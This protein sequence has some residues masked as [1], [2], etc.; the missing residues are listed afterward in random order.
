[1]ER[2]D[3]R[4]GAIAAA[5][6][7]A[8]FLFVGVLYPAP[9]PVLFLGL[10]LGSL[11]AL[12]AMGLVL[13]YRANHIVNF[14]QGSLGAV[15][16]ILAASLIV[17]PGWPF[18][19][20][21]AVGLVTAIVLGA[22]VEVAVI[23]RFAK[24]PRLVLTVATIGVGLLLDVAT[25]GIP[26][27][28]D[29]DSMPQPPVPFHFRLRWFPV[30]FNAG[31][32]L[33]VLVV[34]VVGVL[35]AV[36]FRKTRI[37]IA[38]RAS[39]ESSDRAALLGVPVKRVNTLVWVVAAAMSGL[40]VLLR[41]PIQGVAI[42]QVLGPSLLLRALAAAVIGRMESLPR[43]FVAAITLGMVEQA[44]LFETHRTIV[45]DGVL[46][47]VILVAL[48]VQ[49]GGAVERARD[50][51]ISTWASTKEVRP[52]PR[53][54]MALR[55][56]K[57]GVYGLGILGALAL[58][59][60]PLTWSASRVNLFGIG[61]VS[62]M[63]ICSLVILTGWAGQISLGQY[64]FVA[65]GSSVA[66]TLALQ[67][68]NFFVCLLVAGLVGAAISV[69]IGIPALRIRGP[70]F[71]V[72]SLAFALA[73][74]TYFLNREFFRWLVP[75]QAKRIF[76]PV[77]FDKFDLESEHTYYFVL[78]VAFALTAAAVWRLRNSRT[79]R[80][81][82]ANRDNTRAAQSY[83]ISP[84]RAQ[85]T[86]FA[87]SGLIAG[88]AG[89][90]YVFDQRGLSSTLLRP[91]SS[92]NL[93]AIAVVGGL[94]SVPGAIL[95]SAYLTWVNYSPFTRQVLSRLLASGIGLLGI[96][97]VAPGGLN[98]LMYDLRDAILR[99]IARWRGVVVPS[100]LAD[101]RVLE[102][103]DDTLDLVGAEVPT[104]EVSRPSDDPL[105]VVRDLEV[106][107]GRTQVLF[108]VDFHVERG[109]IVAL[110]G[111][112]G[113]GK[114]TLLSAIAGRV[115]P[116]AGTV[117]YDGHD[118][119]GATPGT[120]VGDG[121]V[122]VPGGKGVFP[123]L[124]VAENLS[125]AGWLYQRDPEYLRAATEQVLEFFPVL[126]E[127]W[128]QR[129]GN[130]SGGEQQMLT[131]GQ[132]FIAKP[133]LLMIDELSLGLAPVIVE[134]LLDIVRAIHDSGTTIVLV[135]QSVNVAITIA[136]RAVFMEKGEVRFDGPTSDL[137]DRPDILRA[138]FL[139]GA[140]AGTKQPATAAA[141]ALDK[142]EFVP[143]CPHCGREHPLALELRDVAVSFGGV[144]AVRG[145]DLSLREG[146][147]V[148]IIG[149]NG[150]GKTTVLDLISGFVRPD[151]GRVLLGADDVTELTPWARAH[152]GLGR[153]FQDAR[154]FP[155]MTVRQTIA[156]ALERHV[157]V[158]DALAALVLSPAVTA[159]ERQ[160][161]EEVTRLIDLMGL[162]AFADKFVG[163]LSTGS[164]R[165]VDLACVLAHQ[166]T[167]LLLDEPSSGIA[168]RETEA[169]GPLL[170]DIR[171][172]TGAA[173][174]V[175]EHDMPLITSI[176]DELVALELGAVIATGT[177]DEVIHD[178]QV[179][180]G[181][182]GGTEEIIRRSGDVE[183]KG[184]R[185]RSEPIKAAGR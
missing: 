45:V 18:F 5:G 107:Y 87:L 2:N 178:P 16:A 139:E 123:T 96:L 38:V 8:L 35:L 94:G 6:L 80:A 119:T 130:L 61:V 23:R 82:V 106:A 175:I 165:I 122:L 32:L 21:V 55:E 76:R 185:R 11:S 62:A 168:Q 88:V 151:S 22:V 95:G 99:R 77:L 120:V 30:V 108:G 41:L 52:I 10:V 26:K 179:V 70:F 53:E 67:G 134:Q 50:A 174:I 83:G 91:E 103:S 163:E 162:G 182:L 173:M 110:L 57:V 117:T 145:V 98:G 118:L 115:R 176:S 65:W 15:A 116:A 13:V 137:L 111:T 141:P 29:Y 114:S 86:A 75:D 180:E 72:T 27:L 147:I 101:V 164:R 155:A 171:R 64:A 128:D 73:T 92:L 34:P 142:Q 166:P 36:F 49:R 81:L 79:G 112:N 84:I 172:Q 100:L 159:S 161:D 78:L 158:P 153:S 28:F 42:G 102:E 47:G 132:A 4:A 69:A 19:P 104:T 170:L 31:H 68:K 156:T 48:L 74:G 148:G 138:V 136:Q 140:A 184:K 127:R 7:L 1:V 154:L 40:G 181:Y 113:A 56:V 43:T 93:F 146:Q 90:L 59:F 133:K 14:A 20:A 135:E 25:L 131:L 66:G 150:A 60:V 71:A 97:L 17:G 152:L 51:G 24:A 39:A 121:V 37:G 54:L 63:I 177:P 109:E 9:M 149:P 44:V 85:L 160:V 3:A 183:G 58:V 157:E 46:F 12:V 105:L 167:V 129:A 124:T 33:I 144:R 169:L 126:R 143:V 89:G 125:L